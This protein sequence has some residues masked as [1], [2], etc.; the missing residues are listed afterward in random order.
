MEAKKEALKI[1][2][3]LVIANI[4][5]KSDLQDLRD[6]LAREATEDASAASADNLD[7]IISRLHG[8]ASDLEAVRQ[9]KS[10]AA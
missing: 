1:V 2:G 9:G 7:E 3:R 10:A 8:M 5:L 4:E 6:A